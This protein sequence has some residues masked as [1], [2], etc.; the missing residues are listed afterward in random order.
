MIRVAKPGTKFVIS[1]ETEK[2][3][4]SQYERCPILRRHFEARTEP[5]TDPTAFVARDMQEV[6]S[7]EIFQGRLYCLTF[8]TPRKPARTFTAAERRQILSSG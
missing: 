4:K 1:D 3:V 6:R 7:R 2:V 8:R 5:V